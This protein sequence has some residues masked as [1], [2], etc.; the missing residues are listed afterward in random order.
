MAQFSSYTS[1]VSY[2]PNRGDTREPSLLGWDPTLNPLSLGLWVLVIL[3]VERYPLHSESP[4]SFTASVSIAS[5][6][7]ELLYSLFQGKDRI[8]FYN[9]GLD[10]TDL[11][12]V[13]L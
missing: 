12:K 11:L 7:L 8:V 1:L 6:W 3:R 9:A 5:S 2:C 4:Y 10:K 13:H